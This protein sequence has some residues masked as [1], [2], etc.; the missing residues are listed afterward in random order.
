MSEEQ[1]VEHTKFLLKFISTG[2][3]ILS[4]K[5]T[6]LIALVL[7]FCLFAYAMAYPDTWRFASATVFGILVFLPTVWLEIR[8][9]S[10]E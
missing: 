1:T 2:I 7:N 10:K 8:A 3:S 9:V 5:I 4:V 6:M